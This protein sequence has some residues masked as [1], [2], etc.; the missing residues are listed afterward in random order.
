MA[1]FWLKSLS[2]SS[3]LYGCE[4]KIQKC[5]K[6]TLEINNSLSPVPYSKR[7]LFSK[8][9]TFDFWFMSL[10]IRS[11]STGYDSTQ[12]FKNALRILQRLRAMLHTIRKN[13]IQNGWL[14]KLSFLPS[15]WL[16][17]VC[18]VVNMGWL[19]YTLGYYF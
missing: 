7:K 16:K 11:M 14:F 9:L 8:W 15:S 19:I 3:M 18:L 4:S 5:F 1:D 13:Y 17:N 12:R 6:N 2:I 10:S